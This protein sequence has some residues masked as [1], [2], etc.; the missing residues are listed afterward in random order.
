MGACDEGGM[1]DLVL[2]LSRVSLVWPHYRLRIF[3]IQANHRYP[4][5]NSV[6]HIFESFGLMEY[7]F[8]K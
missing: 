4:Y 3:K 6:C 8:M 7:S 5:A 2:V 1:G